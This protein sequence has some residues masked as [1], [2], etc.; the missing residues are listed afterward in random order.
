[1]NR[2]PDRSF[3]VPVGALR[4][5]PGSRRRV[6]V[7]SE[8]EGLVRQRLA[9]SRGRAGPPR[10]RARGR[11]RRD[12]RERDRH[13]PLGRRV[14]ALPGGGARGAARRGARALRRGR[15][16]GDDLRPRSRGA[17]PGTDRPRRVYPRPAAR[18]PLQRGVPRAVPGVRCQ[19]Q[20]RAVRVRTVTGPPVG[21]SSRCSLAGSPTTAAPAGSGPSA[22]G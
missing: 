3:V 13:D 7:E 1:M 15:R 8:L 18:A 20:P 9:R 14:P 4:R 17:R 10:G 5:A 22:G 12:P 21:R 6:Q 16:R 19:S 11:A 2:R